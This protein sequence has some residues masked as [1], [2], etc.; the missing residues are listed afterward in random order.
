MSSHN[1]DGVFLYQG[2]LCVPNVDGL[3]DLILSEGHNSQ[4]SIY[5]ESIKMYRHLI[6]VYWLNDMKKDIASFV[7]ELPNYQQVKVEIQRSGGLA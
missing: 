2:R 6:E 3:R 1:G 7:V 4:Y 5:L